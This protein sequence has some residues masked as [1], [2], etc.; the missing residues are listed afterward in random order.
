LIFLQLIFGYR[1]LAQLRA[2]YP[3]VYAEP[4]AAVLLNILFPEMPSRVDN[5]AYV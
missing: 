4:E 3:D 5:L 2:T 1:S